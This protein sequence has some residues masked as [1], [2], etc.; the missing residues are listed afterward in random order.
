MASYPA[1]LINVHIYIKRSPNKTFVY[2]ESRVTIAGK[3]MCNAVPAKQQ[4]IS[5]LTLRAI[6]E[7]AVKV[8][9]IAL[10]TVLPQSSTHNKLKR[11]KLLK[12]LA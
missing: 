1:S 11:I 12:L 6:Y 8:M 10:P 3:T 7:E 5:N 9:Y 2:C 4:L